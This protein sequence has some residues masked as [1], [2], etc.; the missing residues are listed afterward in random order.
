M[1]A[2]ERVQAHWEAETAGVRYGEGTDAGAFYERI[3]QVRYELE[4]YIPDFAG[5][6]QYSG[7]RVLEIGVGGGVDFSQF[8]LHGANAIGI[9]FTKAAI[10]HTSERLGLQA[11]NCE[12]Y[13]ML[14]LADSERLPF[15]EGIFD[16][17][18]S[19][20]V[21]HHTPD[22]ESAFA[23][24]Y[25]VLKPG[26]ELKVMVYH[27]PSWTG[28][29]LWM[30]Y[31]LLKG[32]FHISPKVSIYEYLESPGTK[33]YSVAQAKRMLLEAGFTEVM[34]WTK[35]NPSDLLEIKASKRY[36]GAVYSIIWALYPRWLVRLLGDRFGL[37]LLLT[38]KKS[39]EG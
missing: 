21:L 18:Y 16:L 24:M 25:R 38:A 20:G 35:L 39:R 10:G 12:G 28:W 8:V 13:Y 26:G 1:C 7:K 34:G 33:S 19:W 29:M 17:V 30:R 31:A 3:K 14:A 9:D 36:E 32:R 22:T 11:L 37:N 6:E 5:F 23:E 4:P 15:Q 2:K 27:V